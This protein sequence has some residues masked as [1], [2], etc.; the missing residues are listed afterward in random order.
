MPA[1][2]Q[3][4]LDSLVGPLT[5]LNHSGHPRGYNIPGP[6][7][8]SKYLKNKLGPLGNITVSHCPNNFFITNTVIF[9]V[10]SEQSNGFV[11]QHC[12]GR[13]RSNCTNFASILFALSYS[14]MVPLQIDEISESDRLVEK[15]LNLYL[16]ACAEGS[17]NMRFGSVTFFEGST[18]EMSCVLENLL[19]RG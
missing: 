15:N 19:Q 6:K 5:L 9:C 1:K 4:F 13:L 10:K 14:D 17:M 16:K 18:D 8:K 11:I 7:R 2:V 3:F 12:A